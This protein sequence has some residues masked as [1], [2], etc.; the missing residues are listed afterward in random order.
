[1]LNARHPVA[2]F[3]NGFGDSLLALPALR[4]L[5][6]IFHGRLT[7][8]CQSGVGHVFFSDL[9]LRA[10]YA[11]EMRQRPQGGRMF[12]DGQVASDLVGCDLFLS[13]NMWH[14]PSSQSLL[15]R[16]STPHSVGFFPDF[17]ITLPRYSGKHSADLTFDVPLQLDPSLKLEDFAAPPTFAADARRLARQLRMRVASMRVMVVHADSKPEKMWEAE[18]FV[19]VLDAFLE[20]HPDF[21]VFVV[22]TKNL[23]LDEGRMGKRIIPCYGLPLPVALSLVGE[24]DLFLGID[25]CALHAADLFRVPGLGLFGPTSCA[26][27]GFR[28]GPHRHICGGKTMQG[29]GVTNVLD[30]LESLLAEAGAG[31]RPAVSA[32]T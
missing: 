2:I 3:A 11:Y 14:S 27:W 30:G 4:A 6:S 19:T 28:F 24:A 20:R 29:I 12:D 21:V 26:E 18:R 17:A 9:P 23:H 8:V 31:E 7:L 10:L 22:G 15:A 5:A 32:C 25:S 16:L 13:L 1:M